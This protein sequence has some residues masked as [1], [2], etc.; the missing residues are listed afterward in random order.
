MSEDTP[1]YNV[2]KSADR[3]DSLPQRLA[4]AMEWAD[5]IID[6]AVRAS[7]RCEYCDRDLLASVDAYKEW[8]HDHIVPQ[9]IKEDNGSNNMALSCRTCNVSFKGKWDPSHGLPDDASRDELV[10][11]VR[12]YVARKRTD[13]FAEVVKIR[14]I[15]Y[16][17]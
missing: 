8:Q 10:A 9:R 12:Q 5:W 7:F 3:S 2:L 14:E 17:D 6:I 4:A 15:V 1:D 13:M 11:A 16:G